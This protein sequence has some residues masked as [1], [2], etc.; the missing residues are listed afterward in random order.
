MTESLD[1]LLRLLQ[2]S[3]SLGLDRKV[4]VLERLRESLVQRVGG[5]AKALDSIITALAPTL[6]SSQVIACQAALA[7]IQPL[8]EY[9]VYEANVQTLKTL[10]HFILPQLLDRLGDGRMAVRELALSTLVAMWSELFALQS[11]KPSLEVA[12]LP[13]SRRSSSIPR[14]TSPFRSRITKP[15]A[16][17]SPASLQWSAIN[18]FEREVQ[19]QGFGHKTWRVR[20]MILEWLV[21][22]V[23]QFPDFPAARYIQAAF[24]LLDDSQDAVRFGSK[25]AL[26]TIYHT[27]PSLQEPIVTKAQGL[28]PHRPTV[29]AA[30]TAPK[31]ELAGMPSS[32]YGGI[33]SS[34]RLGS[35]Q[36]ARPR[37]R[38]NGPR[39][40]SRIG[41]LHSALPGIHPSV[42]PLPSSSD[43]RPG[44]RS[45]SQQGFRPG[46]RTG[47]SSPMYAGRNG[48]QLLPSLSPS[49]SQS[50]TQ[51]T[52]TSR[53]SGSPS[54]PHVGAPA[55][56]LPRPA[57]SL[58]SRRAPPAFGPRRQLVRQ[59]SQVRIAPAFAPSQTV[60]I[61]VKP[62]NVPSKQSLAAEFSRTIGFFAGR[63]TEDNWVQRE[64]AVGLYRGIVW[65][66]AALE[67]R[68]VLVSQLKEH[69]HQIM[70]AVGSLRTSLSSFAMGLCD[71][72]AL[73]IG[74][75]AGTLFDAI[76]DAL[77]KQCSQTKKIGAQRASKSLTIAYQSFPLRAKSL[78]QLR[79]RITEKSAVLRLAVV[80]VCTGIVRSH[81]PFIDP[82]DRRNTEIFVH[83]TDVVKAGL[84]DAQPSVREPSRE[85]FW[86]LYSV[87]EVHGKKV[88]AEL[89]DSVGVSL[90]RDRAKYAR[91]MSNSS[92][93][94]SQHSPDTRS[95]SVLPI[96]RTPSGTRGQLPSGRASF[97]SARESMMPSMSA[98]VTHSPQ[99]SLDDQI[100]LAGDYE[101]NGSTSRDPICSLDEADEVSSNADT[102][103]VV[104]VE[105]SPTHKPHMRVKDLRTSVKERMSL[106]LIDFRNM[107]IGP[108]LMDIGSEPERI[109]EPDM[110]NVAGIDMAKSDAP[111][112]VSITPMESQ[113]TTV[114]TDSMD[115]SLVLT[116]G[117]RS[118]VF[119]AVDSERAADDVTSSTKPYQ[120]FDQ[121]HIDLAPS[122]A[123]GQ[124]L[125]PAKTPRMSPSLGMS[126]RNSGAG[127]MTTLT[128]QFVTPR[129]QSARYWNG[130]LGAVP[131]SLHRSPVAESP[132]PAEMPQRLNMV[133]ICLQRLAEN[134]G[135]N[136]A[137]FRSL[138]RFA[139]EESSTVWMDEA[140][141]GQAYLG[142][143]LDA[144]LR[145][146]QNPAE[147]RDA[148]FTKDSCFDVLRVLV[149]RKSQYFSLD[150]ARRLLLEVLR[151][152][153]FESTILSGSA[154]DVFYDIAAHLDADLCFEL[155]EDF[156]KRAP[157]PAM[158]DLAAQKPGYAAHLESQESTML[159]MD[160][161]GVFKMDNALAGVLEF[162]AE[163]V[164]RLGS[165]DIIGAQEL[166]KFLPYSIAC[167]VHPRSQVRK[168][169]L[170]PMI[171]VH[172]KLGASDA[173]FEELLLR[174]T[175]DE[176][177][178][179]L[180]P[181]AKY[182]GQLHRPELRKLV[183]TF[184]QPR[185]AA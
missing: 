92:Q 140:Q 12:D 93:Q 156:F 33:R 78:E 44:F 102:D 152:R 128:G 11:R 169:A 162:T 164:R 65:G 143:I 20:E 66:N 51:L 72:I 113:A 148:V 18:T 79:L 161:M 94:P 137:L 56:L 57:S 119:F 185:R 168:A 171:V 46:S 180:N 157:L 135:V 112:M 105:L 1:Q 89:P 183:W 123:P 163:V 38:M 47:F 62:F 70:Q 114:M 129:T 120:L 24:A 103:S 21:A 31:G 13:E 116:D 108:S 86:E 101:V 16:P 39:S 175:P 26:N 106:G 153:F 80:M 172:E 107:D 43:I 45:M 100:G 64:R 117:D 61:D 142:R 85:L 50:S 138:A 115:H 167:F 32:P 147:G 184:Y 155:A 99:R 126:T 19:T 40:D 90:H 42:P 25:R 81:G 121:N 118:A 141:G 54:S 84:T 41:G 124:A 110:A 28:S 125:T 49:H 3:Q 160:P 22:C 7:C 97:G 136:E 34:S 17:A 145:W 176:L 2:S 111:N 74:P 109:L 4:A 59:P 132:L 166:D 131:S 83:L 150:T 96:S 88:L 53:D 87:S 174:A 91:S 23:E 139:K 10:L 122:T 177:G 133:E 146:L 149:R 77:L 151:N 98:L 178:S 37:S 58:N 95:P 60:P 6:G 73:R 35:S 154:E 170:E 30:I 67:F 75:H 52:G 159:E 173:V 165:P 15:R 27:H 127:S 182:I 82:S 144:C 8:T 5:S 104:F 36:I 68:D 69:I 9:A 63:E 76:V 55:S 14:F 130:P 71:D 158:Q 134:T 48:H 29:L 181:L 179:S